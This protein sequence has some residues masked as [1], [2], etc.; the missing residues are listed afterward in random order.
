MGDQPRQIK[1]IIH[2]CVGRPQLY[3]VHGG[4]QGQVDLAAVPGIAQFIRRYG[5]GCKRG[6]GLGLV[7]TELLGQ[8]R[9]YQVPQ[10]Y[11]VDNSDQLDMRLCL[12]R[13]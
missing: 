10:R 11:V 9:G 6:M 4:M 1:G 5:N 3:A 12:F 8:F 13:G 2:A 7:K